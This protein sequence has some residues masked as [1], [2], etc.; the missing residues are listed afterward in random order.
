M[1]NNV[2]NEKKQND[3]FDKF[4]DMLE[5]NTGQHP[6]L[7]FVMFFEKYTINMNIILKIIQY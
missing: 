6:L 3:I 1:C 2:F 7:T 4:A 5:T